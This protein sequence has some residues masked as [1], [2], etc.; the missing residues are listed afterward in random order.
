MTK[1]TFPREKWIGTGVKRKEDL[2]LLRGK[3]Q[4]SDDLKIPGVLY[5]GLVR[6]PYA[7]ARIKKIDFEKALEVPG[8]VCTLTGQEVEELTNPVP[9][10]LR[11]PYSGIEDYCMAVG[12]SRYV[13]EVVAAVVAEDKYLVEDALGLVEVEYE[14]LDPVVDPEKAME[15]SSSLVHENVPSNLVWEGKYDYGDVDG[16]FAEADLVIKEQFY[17]HRFTSA[18]LEN[19]VVIADYDERREFFTIWSNNQRPMF[20]HRFVMTALDVPGEKIRYINPDIGGGFGI[21]NDSYLYLILMALLAQRAGRPVKWVETRSEHLASSLHGNEVFYDAEL[22]VKK[23]GTILGLKA[24]ALHDEGAYMRREP[25]GAINFI[26]H[27]TVGYNFQNLSMELACVATN[28]CPVGPNR[29]Y[30][31]MQQCFLVERLIDMA[32]KKLQLDPV[33]VRLKNFVQ[34]EQMPYETP[35]GCILDGGDYPAVLKKAVELIDYAKVREEQAKGRESGKYIGVGFAMGMDGCPVNSSIQRMMNPDL[36]ASGDAEAAWVKINPDGQIVAA[37]GSTP[38][39]QGH[40]T[41]VS[42]IVADALSVHPDDVY[43]VAGFDSSVNPSCPQ[44]GTYASRFAIVGVGAVLGAALKVRT[45]VL[46]IAAHLLGDVDIEELE[47]E[48]GRVYL[49]KSKDQGVSLEDVAR[50]AWLDLAN[51]PDE[52]EA[53]LFGHYVYR[54]DFKLPVDEKRG[55][56]SLTYSYA[57]TGA[58][59]EVDVET[60]KIK[61]L[62]LVCVDDAGKRLNPLIVEGQIHGAIGHQLGAA[63]YERLIYDDE[64]QLLTSTFKDY[65]APSAADFPKFEVDYVDN[66]SLATPWGARGA[67]EGGGSPLIVVGSAVSDALAPF[68]VEIK[69]SHVTPEDVLKQIMDSP[70]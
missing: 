4:Y 11:D 44:S 35:T 27:A 68:N 8:V 18:P 62:R 33:E 13:G 26:R 65:A 36:K 53:G 20:N 55:N 59:V 34:P 51:L 48:D 29:S 41:I 63:L 24:R 2:R 61:I 5:A 50:T 42:Q 46:Q 14:P 64:G 58:V 30:G 70:V 23:D 28:K 31:K 60:G 22:A 69:S 67:G 3:G 40:E 66:P 56:F 37:V 21:K 54:P 9:N 43:A 38:Q 52:I 7:H 1:L 19:S 32:A 17:F 39:G 57:V 47:L 6:S 12:K 15:S 49:K 45:K 10:N 16:A 25:I